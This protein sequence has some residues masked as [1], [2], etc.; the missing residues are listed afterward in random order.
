MLETYSL[1]FD[2][3]S[4]LFAPKT[5]FAMDS[6]TL[7]HLETCP[8]LKL[9]KCSKKNR[10]T[11]STEKDH[12]D[13]VYFLLEPNS[14]E[15]MTCTCNKT[16]NINDLHL[17]DYKKKECKTSPSAASTSDGDASSIVPSEGFDDEDY[18]I[19]DIEKDC[20]AELDKVR[21]Q[22]LKRFKF[23]DSYDQ[24]CLPNDFA[25]KVVAHAHLSST[26]KTEVDKNMEV[27]TIDDSSSE[28]SA[29]E[30]ER[31]I[32]SKENGDYKYNS[33]LFDMK[34]NSK[35]QEC[36]SSSSDP[37]SISFVKSYKTPENSVCK[38][39]LSKR[40]IGYCSDNPPRISPLFVI[41]QNYHPSQRPNISDPHSHYFSEEDND[42]H[43]H[44]RMKQPPTYN[45]AIIDIE[46]MSDRNEVA[47]SEEMYD[48]LL[49]MEKQLG[50]QLD[51]SL[52]SDLNAR[53]LPSNY[54]LP[55]SK[56]SSD[57]GYI[58]DIQVRDKYS[59]REKSARC[60]QLLNEFKSSKPEDLQLM[61]ETLDSPDVTNN[62][63]LD[64]M[65]TELSKV[66]PIL[67][68]SNSTCS[69]STHN[70]WLV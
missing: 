46:R 6:P 3:E 5:P 20:V 8:A 66:P 67:K 60:A 16:V 10:G 63:I 12:S 39:Q 27:N 51:D 13:E 18:E 53:T 14:K 47:E 64:D 28:N 2:D 56:N 43:A 55:H 34:P 19:S 68:R 29:T 57:T 40:D 69:N 15:K 45:Q 17:T 7:F 65:I 38:P 11:H 4:K 21:A 42:T 36:N 54:R 59:H 49:L 37:D 61:G 9:G 48:Q 58:S 22:V 52:D 33:K 26:E 24:F 70:E 1:E 50:V 32:K 44:N 41:S 25:S 23:K 62:S 35:F 31:R 30:S